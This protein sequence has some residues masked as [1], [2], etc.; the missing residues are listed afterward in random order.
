MR[1]GCNTVAFRREPL[2]TALA[3]IA[4]A[5]YEY[6]EIEGNL[7]WCPH[8]DPWT[9]DPVKFADRVRSHGFKGIAA[10]GNHRELLTQEQ[11]VK[12]IARGLE[13]CRAAG[14]PLVLTGEGSLGP[15]MSEAEALSI[16]RDRLS[17]LA[18]VAEKNQVYL[19]MEDHGSVSLGSQY[20]LLTIVDLV[21]SDWL[22]VNFDTANIRRG[23]YVGTDR[24]KWEWKLGEATSFSET[25]LLAKLAH[26]VKHVH[27]KDV[28]GRNAVV[29]G[30]GEIDLA[31]C[32]RLL[33]Q[34]H[35]D[36]VLSYETEGFEEPAEAERMILVSRYYMQGML[37][38][39]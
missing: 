18:E 38:A 32:V 34:A 36:G 16:L 21:Q 7:K 8:A 25:V 10:L 20:G 28:V 23:D 4:A 26:R 9:E 22:V 1:I 3:R 13:W 12:D 33:K 31:G 30:E 19:A 35:F 6:V 15:G 24:E 5:G 27:F 14:I 17:Y 11:G 2:D 39:L 37:A 29:A